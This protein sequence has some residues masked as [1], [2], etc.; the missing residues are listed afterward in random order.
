MKGLRQW[1]DQGGTNERTNQCGKLTVAC[2]MYKYHD[3]IRQIW[4]V[5]WYDMIW[6]VKTDMISD[7]V[8][9]CDM[10]SAARMKGLISANGGKLES[11]PATL[12]TWTLDQWS[13]WSVSSSLSSSIM[14]WYYSLFFCCV[15]SYSLNVDINIWSITITI[16]VVMSLKRL[17]WK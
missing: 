12:S 14:L 4:L 3:I 6:Y 10:I 16:T 8:F 7:S 17:E 13:H 1:Y 2:I 15:I 11:C 5:I 9:L